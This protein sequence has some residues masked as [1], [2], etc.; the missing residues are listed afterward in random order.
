L[1][2]RQKWIPAFAGLTPNRWQLSVTEARMRLRG[3]DG[4]ALNLASYRL[5]ANFF[6]RSQAGIDASRQLPL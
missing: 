4:L 2:Q 1:F 3:D 5:F 6:T